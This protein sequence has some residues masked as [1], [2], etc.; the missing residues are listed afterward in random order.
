MN[1]I[2]ET[3]RNEYIARINR[4]IEYIEINI[5]ERLTLEKLSEISCFSPFHFH[6]V[7]HAYIGETPNDFVNRIRL[8]KAATFL[9][10]NSGQNITE[11]AFKYG[12]SS[13][14]SFA[15]AFKKHFGFSASGWCAGGYEKYKYSKIGKTE[16]K[17]G[18]DPVPFEDYVSSV[19][20]IFVNTDQ[21]ENKM[22]VEIKQM[23]KLHV[24]YITVYGSYG[25]NIGAAYEKICRWAGPRGLLNQHTKFVGVAFDSPDITP[26]EKLR[27]NACITV[28][29]ETTP[30]KE[31]NITDIPE[32]RCLVANYSGLQEGISKFYDELFKISLPEYG[33]LPDDA[34]A[35]EIYLNDPKT[36]PDKKF[37]MNVYIP[38]KPL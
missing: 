30:E 13:S 6:R 25:E 35:Y 26:E 37:V 38:V 22:E 9:T 28:P 24:A 29:E 33:F 8:E 5:S 34:P 31:I 15:R 2:K 4:V 11:V 14:A 1:S 16:S 23:P 12:F 18:K 20:N 19:N 27:Y 10:Y 17:N 7:F 36:D 32:A 3:S 21:E